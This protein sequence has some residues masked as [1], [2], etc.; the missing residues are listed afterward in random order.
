MTN[1][2]RRLLPTP[3]GI[4]PERS[5]GEQCR[6]SEVHQNHDGPRSVLRA[7][8][9]RRYLSHPHR[10]DQRG[11]H[12]LAL[13]QALSRHAV[14]E[15]RRLPHRRLLRRPRHTVREPPRDRGLLGLQSR[16]LAARSRPGVGGARHVLA[17][18]RAAWRRA[19]LAEPAPK[20]PCPAPASTAIW[21]PGKP[22][23]SARQRSSGRGRDPCPPRRARWR[24]WCSRVHAELRA[25]EQWIN[26]KRV[27]GL[28]R[29]NH[30]VGRHL[31]KKNLRHPIDVLLAWTPQHMPGIERAC[32]DF[33]R[34]E[35]D[36]R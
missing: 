25:S 34:G 33:D 35:E 12:L 20:S 1:G 29:V 19:R 13:Q 4:S 3:A 30:I 23:S 27:T 16:E 18:G 22:A 32:D 7:M 8:R 15:L 24:L 21:P 14:P 5:R 26:R 2:P 31:R 36:C 17:A 28:M 9:Q 6:E 11:G 10:P